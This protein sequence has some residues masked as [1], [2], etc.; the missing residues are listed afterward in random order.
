MIS[1]Q[2]YNLVLH[3]QFRE[4][5]YQRQTKPAKLFQVVLQEN[6]RKWQ[7]PG[8]WAH[9]RE[10]GQETFLKAQIAVS[11]VLGR[12]RFNTVAFWVTVVCTKRELKP[13]SKQLK[14]R[15]FRSLKASKKISFW[16][17]YRISVP[18]KSHVLLVLLDNKIHQHV[19]SFFFLFLST[20][21]KWLWLS[22]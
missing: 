21:M 15:S 9:N 18:N 16:R 14:D 19:K 3:Q 7:A 22:I 2:H 4:S 6:A 13:S 10:T 12:Q 1:K 11:E 17:Q 20:F 8:W 5:K